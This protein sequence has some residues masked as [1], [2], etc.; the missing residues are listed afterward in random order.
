MVDWRL[1]FIQINNLGQ[2][3]ITWVIS[4]HSFISHLCRLSTD[5]HDGMIVVIKEGGYSKDGY[6]YLF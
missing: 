6:V 2:G 3:E 1:S 5:C 4:V